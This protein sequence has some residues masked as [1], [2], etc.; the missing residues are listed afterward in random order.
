MT[1]HFRRERARL[2]RRTAVGRTTIALLEINH[3]EVIALREALIEEGLYPL[4]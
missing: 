2:I 1:R 4:D 3:P